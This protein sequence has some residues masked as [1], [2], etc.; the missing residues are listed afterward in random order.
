MSTFVVD[1]NWYLHR[2][3]YTINPKYRTP[4]QALNYAFI[5]MIC[6]DALATQSSHLLVA[7]DG[8]EVFRYKL[9]PKYKANRSDNK[10]GP[11]VREGFKDVYSYLPPLL[12]ALTELGIPWIQPRKFE[13]DDALCSAAKQ[14]SESGIVYIGAKDK[15]GY[16]YLTPN[17][18][19]YDSSNKVKGESKPLYIRYS[20][21]PK[22]KGVKANQMASYQ[23]L[24]GDAID[25]I[26]K[27]LTPVKARKLLE[28]YG[29]ISKAL[30]SEEYKDLNSS[31]DILKLNAKLVT[32]RTDVMIPDWVSTIIPRKAID[33]EYKKALPK[34]Y[35]AYIDFV[36]PKAKG[37]F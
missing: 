18:S 30:K 16:Q 8:P 20:D 2:C 12:S 25:N 32:L 6:K 13:A 22:L 10:T 1:G 34:S 19:M 14:Y 26:P 11:S 15:D 9:Y 5:S 24:I 28:K 33:D 36:H 4:E 27:I 35:F 29:S 31:L 3:Y 37:L 17:V 23:C 7:F 21:V